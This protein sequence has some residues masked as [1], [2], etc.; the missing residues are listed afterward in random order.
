MA[1]VEIIANLNDEIK[2][3]QSDSKVTFQLMFSLS[4]NHQKGKLLATVGGIVI[5]EVKYKKFGFYFIT[6]GFK[7][8]CLSGE[9]LT[10][11][12]KSVRMSDKKNQQ[13]VIG[14]IKHVLKTISAGEF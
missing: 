11:L 2:K 10:D 13:K 12:L 4:E 3:L 14:E 1:Q 5:K 7:L 8:K 9:Q 6:D